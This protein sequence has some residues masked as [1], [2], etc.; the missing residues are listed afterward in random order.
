MMLGKQLK[1]IELILTLSFG[2]LNHSQWGWANTEHSQI[3]PKKII[4][5]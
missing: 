3:H 5:H 4:F 2:A 1:S